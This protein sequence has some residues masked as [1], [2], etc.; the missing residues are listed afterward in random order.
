[1]LLR[2]RKT[3]RCQSSHTLT[4]VCSQGETA[5]TLNSFPSP[6]NFCSKQGSS[7]CV[8]VCVCVGLPRSL[9]GKESICSAGDPGSILRLR[10]SPGGGHGNPLQYS[11]LENSMDRG[12]WWATVQEFAELDMT[13]TFHFLSLLLLLSR[14][15]RVRLCATP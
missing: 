2:K 6:K 3:P 14:F 9:R 5:M 8:C 10:R 11:F 1:M 12:A 7:M 15:S 4:N 13:N